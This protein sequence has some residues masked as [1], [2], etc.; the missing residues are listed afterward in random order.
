[1]RDIY[2]AL[3]GATAAW[4]QLSSIA[5]N[6]AN[7]STQGYREARVSFRVAEEGG[8]QYAVSGQGGYS[9]A[10]GDLETDNVETHLAL[11]G[12]GFFALDD[13]T[14]TR[15]GS[16]RL[17]SEGTLVSAEGVPVHVEGGPAQFQPGESIVVGR[18]G[19]VA[20]SKSG[21]LGKLDI[22]GLTAPAPLGGNRWGGTPGDTPDGTTVVQGALEGSNVDTMRGM[23]EMM[24]ANRFFEAQQKAIQTS[25][26]LR[27]RLNRMGGS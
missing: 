11:R 9:A 3:S 24:E 18:D 12:D 20:G 17:D 8:G 10:D 13:G 2:V 27:Q 14:F 1:M 6:V 22:V 16:F 23:V 7:A 25:D 5:N 4:N 15:D 21:N 19:M 26:E